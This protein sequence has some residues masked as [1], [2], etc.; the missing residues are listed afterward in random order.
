MEPTPPKATNKKKTL[1][2]YG[3]RVG[4]GA[5]KNSRGRSREIPK[6][7]VSALYGSGAGTGMGWGWGGHLIWGGRGAKR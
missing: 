2:V 4:H 6:T 3:E 7:I 1:G 5:N